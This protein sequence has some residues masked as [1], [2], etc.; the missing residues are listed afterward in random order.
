M[1][2]LA[3]ALS[4]AVG[5]AVHATPSYTLVAISPAHFTLTPGIPIGYLTRTFKQDA[6]VVETAAWSPAPTAV[7]FD[8]GLGPWTIPVTQAWATPAGLGRVRWTCLTPTQLIPGLPVGPV[9]VRAVGG[10]ARSNPL[11]GRV[12]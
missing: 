8:M 5:W 1:K 4:L 10:G 7:E 9:E 6:L 3:V 2:A 11:M 12:R